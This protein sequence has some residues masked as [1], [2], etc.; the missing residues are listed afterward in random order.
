M[1]TIIDYGL[2]NLLSIQNMLKQI[3]L[4]S[5]ITEDL[6]IISNASN[7]I[8][9]GVGNFQK[10]MENIKKKKIDI[11]IFKALKNNASILGICL[12][13]HLLCN[14][15]DEGNCEGLSIINGEVKKFEF[16]NNSY[17]V[18]HMGWNTIEFEENSF[19]FNKFNQKPKFYFAHSFYLKTNEKLVST[20]NTHHGFK[21][22]TVVEKKKVIGVQFHPEKSHNYGINFFKLFYLKK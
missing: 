8:L 19:F 2:G 18:P 1:I 15:S 7:L 3:G 4:K 13:M 6:D 9:P 10:G 21:F 16:D 12:G 17:K 20:G 5:L 11:S 14:R 22:T